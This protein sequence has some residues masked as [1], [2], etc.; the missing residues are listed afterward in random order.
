MKK[1]L[2]FL[3]FT[4]LIH[5]QDIKLN[6]L[7]SFG[8]FNDAVGFTI[9]NNNVI[10]L[11]AEKSRILKYNSA[12]ELI[13]TNGGF[14]WDSARF[15]EPSDIDSDLLKIYVCDKNNNRIQVFDKDLNFISI[16]TSG[17]NGAADFEYPSVCKVSNPGDLF[18]LDSE[19]KSVFTLN[20]PT[21][22]YREIININNSNFSFED[23]GYFDLDA[24]SN[25]YVIHENKLYIYDQFGNGLTSFNL[26]FTPK[27]IFINRGF[28][29]INTETEIYYSPL[30]PNFVFKKIDIKEKDI[31]KCS[32]V[33]SKLYLLLKNKVKVYSIEK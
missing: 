8:E 14:G 17:E 20:V 22:E 33:E 21:N 25:I 2:I 3:A 32:V 6:Y 10:V 27:N 18:F 31:V 15:D 9:L 4:V 30:Y 19:N 23:P 24:S 7:K 11:E 26:N 12:G 1:I 5:S 16:F 28:I 13:K 29:F